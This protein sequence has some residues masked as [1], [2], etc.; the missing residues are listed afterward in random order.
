[1]KI[2]L[3]TYKNDIKRAILLLNDLSKF[4]DIET[5]VVSD[6]KTLSL[7]KSKID[8]KNFFFISEEILFNEKESVASGYIQQQIV[9]IK[10]SNIINSDYFCID[11]DCR[12]IKKLSISTFY[13]K[14]NNLYDFVDIDCIVENFTSWNNQY[15]N[16][17]NNYLSFIRNIYN[18]V[19]FNYF[20][21][22]IF[23]I[24]T[25][26]VVSMKRQNRFFMYK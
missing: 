25:I 22:G 11:S 6:N 12:I 17:R 21:R 9:K 24:N 13:D 8:H 5:F 2:L 19:F 7:L 26:I 1:L 15:F 14:S 20:K 10:F 3:K 4:S 16:Q 23:F 18:I